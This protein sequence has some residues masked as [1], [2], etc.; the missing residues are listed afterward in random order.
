MIAVGTEINER[1]DECLTCPELMTKIRF[2]ERKWQ[3]LQGLMKRFGNKEFYTYLLGYFDEDGVPVVDDYYIPSQEVSA[4]TADVTEHILPEEVTRRLIGWLHSHHD[5]GAFD[6]GRDLD[7]ANYPVA[8]VIS[9]KGH[10]G[11]IRKRATCGRLMKSEAEIEIIRE[12]VTLL[13]GEEKIL[14][15]TYTWNPI[16]PYNLGAYITQRERKAAERRLGNL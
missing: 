1:L 10:K 15:K 6:S 16:T 12:P 5:M 14:N 8:I 11:Y 2:A 9:N 7:S 13:P 3:D 4:S